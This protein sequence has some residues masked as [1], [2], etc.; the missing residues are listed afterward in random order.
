MS[1]PGESAKQAPW[2]P[3]QSLKKYIFG[4]QGKSSSHPGLLNASGRI[5]LSETGRKQEVELLRLRHD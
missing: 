3:A 2:L 1:I 5:S 4:M